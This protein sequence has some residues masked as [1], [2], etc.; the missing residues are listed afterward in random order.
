ME[1]LSYKLPVFEGP[2]DLLLHLIT[3][4]KHN[5]YDIPIAELLDQ[6]MEQIRAMQE[7]DLDIAS[8]FLEMAARLVHLKSVSLLPK[9]EEAEALKQ[10]LTGQLLEYQEC[11]R[12][13][14][15]LAQRAEFNTFVRQPEAVE[16]DSAYQRKHHPEEVMAAYQNAAGRGKR[17]LPPPPEAFSGIVT[18]RIVSVSSKIIHVLRCLWKKHEVE[19]DRVFEDSREKSELVAT[20]LAVLELV[21]GKRVRIEEESTT[22]KLKL[23]GG[24][25]K[26]WR[27]RSTKQS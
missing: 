17:K 16:F 12:I 25:G 21:K 9:H 11:K 10:D 1:K 5:I 19:Y 8:E 27:S 20:F 3:K 23:L 7:E 15:V 26:V 4:N 22:R 13:A 14:A 24:G 2:L 18:H 6:Y